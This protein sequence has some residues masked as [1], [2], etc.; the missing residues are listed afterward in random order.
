VTA[1][2]LAPPTVAPPRDPRS[3]V[4]LPDRDYHAL[5][6][7]GAWYQVA[8][9]QLEDAIF[10]DR[11]PTIASRCVRRLV[12]ARYVVVE[13]WNRVG[14]N[15]IRL[16]S[17]GRAALIERGIEDHSIFVPERA[18]A[19]KDLAHHLWIVDAGLMLRSV[20]VH[21]DVA[22]CWTLRRRLAAMR[23]P[24]IPDL[25]ALRNNESGTTDGVIAV[26]VDLGG[27]RLKNVFVPKLGV[28]RDLVRSWAG[29]QAAAI[30]VLTV[31]PRRIAALTAAITA[32]PHT[33]PVAVF[34]LPLQQGRPGLAAL[35]TMLTTV[36]A[37][38][39]S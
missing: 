3:I 16:A 30:I 39:N 12:N 29:S 15:L 4:V 23:P 27:E 18:V 22:P 13:R 2:D 24:A 6:F 9:Y 32:L 17:R 34:P 11:S 7:I 1:I 33:V 5:R 28:L 26:E 25:L 10:P 36:I 38:P 14:L 31:G 21:L 37:P 35:R 8:Q 19:V 20:S